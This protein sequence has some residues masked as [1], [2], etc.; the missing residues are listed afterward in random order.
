MVS[1]VITNTMMVTSLRTTTGERVGE[2]LVSLGALTTA[3]LEHYLKIHKGSF[4]ADLSTASIRPHLIQM[5]GVDCSIIMNP[6][7]WEASGHVGGFS[8]P[9]VD[10][11]A[12]KGRLCL[13]KKFLI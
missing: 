1:Q 10:C 8:D 7:V 12:C 6:K 5:V 13:L 11:K 9:M 2:A 3:Q 4:S